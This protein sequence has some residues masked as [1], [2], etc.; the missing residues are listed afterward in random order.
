MAKK[1]ATEVQVEA[2]PPAATTN[3]HS[4]PFAT[5]TAWSGVAQ[6]KVNVWANV[7]QGE[8]GEFTVYSVT[9][10]RSYRKGDEWKEGGG[11]RAQDLP[12]LQHLLTKAYDMLLT[13]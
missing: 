10:G 1:K 6:I 11:Y 4:P 5:F 13:K 3:G 9:F 12:V 2:Q 7:M 8:Q